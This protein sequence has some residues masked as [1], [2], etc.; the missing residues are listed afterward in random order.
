M[1]YST[2]WICPTCA[3]EYTGMNYCPRC[4]DAERPRWQ[5]ETCGTCGYW[6]QATASEGHCRKYAGCV[7]D[8]FACPDW[9]G[10]EP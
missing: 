2:E 4:D 6:V 5:V 3:R 10:R 7:V 9:E 8:E 1:T